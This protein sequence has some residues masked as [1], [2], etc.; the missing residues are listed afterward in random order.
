MSVWLIL[1]DGKNKGK[2]VLQKRNKK[3][4]SFPYICQGTWAGKVED[5]ENLESVRAVE[6][7]ERHEMS[8]VI[9]IRN[10][11]VRI[12]GERDTCFALLKDTTFRTP[13]VPTVFLVEEDAPEDCPH[14]LTVEG[15]RYAVVGEEVLSGRQPYGEQTIPLESSS[16]IFPQ[17]LAG[18]GA[19]SFSSSPHQLSR[20]R[21]GSC[22]PRHPRHRL[23]QPLPGHGWAPSGILPVPPDERACH[24]S[25]RVQPGRG[26]TAGPQARNRGPGIA[27]RE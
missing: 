11:G 21:G 5:K 2:V 9:P 19:L 22:S 16:V 17:R 8:S 25:H 20:A 4:K 14:S 1:Q 15:R 18:A 13:K 6:L 12:L 7:E 3:N 10:L 27:G 23:H 24:D 26:L